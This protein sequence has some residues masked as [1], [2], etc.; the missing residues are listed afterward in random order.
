MCLPSQSWTGA[1]HKNEPK[2]SEYFF[3]DMMNISIESFQL[4]QKKNHFIIIRKD[5]F[6]S[7]EASNEEMANQDFL[8]HLCDTDSENTSLLIN[9]SNISFL[10]SPDTFN[11]TFAGDFAASFSLSALMSRCCGRYGHENS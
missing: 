5:A 2:L 4:L 6:L 7:K 9:H 10:F 1:L 8:L 11:V 3:T